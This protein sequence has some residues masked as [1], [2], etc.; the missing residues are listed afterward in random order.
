[1]A[2]EYVKPYFINEDPMVALMHQVPIYF[3]YKEKDCKALLDGIKIDHRKRTVE[4]FDLKTTRAVYDFEDH[5]V[6]YKYYLQAAFYRIALLSEQS[7]VKQYLDEGYELLDFIFIAVENKISSSHPAVIYV[8][9]S[10]DLDKAVSGGKI[11]NRWIKGIDELIEDYKY[12]E[13]TDRWDLPVDLI[14]SEGR[15]KLRVFS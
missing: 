15:K 5:F 8:T 12:H 10:E 11:G 6:M 14:M 4:P 2:N 7:P 3:K 9:E 13:Q 1:M